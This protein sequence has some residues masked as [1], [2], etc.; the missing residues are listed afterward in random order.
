MYA[1]EKNPNAVVTL[2][3]LKQEIWGDS[4]TVISSDMRAWEPPEKADIL[5]SE[6]LGS[7]GDN[8]LSPECLDGAQKFLKE[9]GISIPLCNY[10]KSL[11]DI[12]HYFHSCPRVWAFWEKVDAW[13]LA[14]IETRFDVSKEE[15]L[16][17]ILNENDDPVLNFVNLVYLI[18]KD[19]IR[20]KE[21][22]ILIFLYL[23]R[24]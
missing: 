22:M 3:N 5:V 11:D 6:L 18:G 2:E 14:K 24:H 4:V 23:S 9:D 10:C 7:F 16:I 12:Y 21:T 1:V 17:G 20:R 19:Y 8:E 13:I 15:L